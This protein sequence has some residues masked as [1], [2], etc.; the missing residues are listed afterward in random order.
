MQL[1][2]N[3]IAQNLPSQVS[4]DEFL[5]SGGTARYF[6]REIAELLRDFG[7]YINWCDSLERRIGKTFGDRVTKD[8]LQSRLADAYG[9][10]YQIQNRPLPRLRDTHGDP[11]VQQT[12]QAS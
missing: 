5:V 12:T 9:L 7:G 1:L 10:F 2:K 3:W 6:Q 8:S 11:D 4:V